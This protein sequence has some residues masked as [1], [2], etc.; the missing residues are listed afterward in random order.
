MQ[1]Y[2]RKSGRHSSI[3]LVGY[4]Q[5]FMGLMTNAGSVYSS[6]WIL[7]HLTE[8]HGIKTQMADVM[9]YLNM[10]KSSMMLKEAKEWIKSTWVG[11]T[12]QNVLV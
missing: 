8:N 10:F 2:R 7:S 11:K 3:D 4:G 9:Q 1:G 6:N 12:V 5:D